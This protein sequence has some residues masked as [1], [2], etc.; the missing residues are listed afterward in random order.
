[1]CYESY[2]RLLT[3]QSSRIRAGRGGTVFGAVA[4][5]AGSIVMVDRPCCI[6]MD[7]LQD[8]STTRHVKKHRSYPRGAPTNTCPVSQDT[9]LIV[10][11]SMS[12]QRDASLHCD[13]RILQLRTRLR[14]SQTNIYS[15]TYRYQ[16]TSRCND[17]ILRIKI[18]L[19][20]AAILPLLLPAFV[21]V[22]LGFEPTVSGVSLPTATC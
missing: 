18:V 19:V 11:V 20:C 21:V 22:T 16:W 14:F 13:F 8:P 15:F 2:K 6:R 5:A 17:L 10:L 3:S 1:M 9:S 7:I 12:V 4:A